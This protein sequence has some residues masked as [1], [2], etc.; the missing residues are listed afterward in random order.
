MWEKNIILSEKKAR[1]NELKNSQAYKRNSKGNIPWWGIELLLHVSLIWC[2]FYSE[3]TFVVII[4]TMWLG[5]LEPHLHFSWLG[6]IVC[7]SVSYFNKAW[8]ENPYWKWPVTR[9]EKTN[10]AIIQSHQRN[11]GKQPALSIWKKL[12]KHYLQVSRMSPSI[13]T[14]S[15]KWFPYHRGNHSTDTL[16]NKWESCHM[17][18]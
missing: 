17:Q 12:M 7:L 13:T 4:K 16:K 18:G 1:F 6:S 11:T 3:N 8:G 14:L 10:T 2:Y 15:Y 5:D 9:K